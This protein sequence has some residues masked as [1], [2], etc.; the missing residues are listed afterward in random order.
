MQRIALAIQLNIVGTSNPFTPGQ[1]ENQVLKLHIAFGTVNNG[2]AAELSAK[3]SE[4]LLALLHKHHKYIKM[5]TYFKADLTIKIS[6]F[7]DVTLCSL[8]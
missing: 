5:D 7:W 6:I 1:K 8:I 3:W 4:L 2:I